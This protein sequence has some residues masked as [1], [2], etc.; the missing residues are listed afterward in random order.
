MTVNRRIRKPTK[1]SDI[2]YAAG[3]RCIGQD[4]ERRG[5]KAIDIQFDGNGYLAQCSYRE[6]PATMPVTLAYT[7]A[8]LGESDQRGEEKRDAEPPVK[9]FLNLVQIFRTIG[10]Y[11]D[12]NEARL[13]RITNNE[14][15]GNDSPCRVEYVTR[16]GEKVVDHRAGSAIYDM[17]VAMYKQRGKP[18][19]TDSR[20]G[21]R[22][23]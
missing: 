3:L 19:G 22:R 12:K 10:G 14:P 15:P 5:I 17:C 16:D 23:R 9:D 7:I 6:P 1:S 11:F 20:N 2:S 18:T 8:D 21:G 13:M 4:L